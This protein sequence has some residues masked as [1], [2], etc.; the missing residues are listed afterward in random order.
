MTGTEH[1]D[2]RQHLVRNRPVDV[3]SM[4]VQCAKH[5]PCPHHD[6]DVD[7]AHQLAL[8]FGRPFEV[9]VESMPVLVAR[10][11]VDAAPVVGYR[12]VQEDMVAGRA[13]AVRVGETLLGRI[14]RLVGAGRAD[15]PKGVLGVTP[16]EGDLFRHSETE[17]AFGGG[18]TLQWVSDP[19]TQ[20]VGNETQ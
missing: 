11:L 14:V 6:A 19:W 4:Q 7:L 17:R 16:A 9:G 2:L 12:G 20:K 5:D 8:L 13:V 1:T 10:A 3:A 15:I 18:E